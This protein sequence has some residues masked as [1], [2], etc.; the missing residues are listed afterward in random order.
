[1][2]TLF[3]LTSGEPPE[4]GLE[5]VF[6]APAQEPVPETPEA[7]AAEAPPPAT[8]MIAYLE[9][10]AQD[11]EALLPSLS[12][13]ELPGSDSPDFHAQ[14]QSVVDRVLGGGAS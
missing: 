8:A 5:K 11:L 1:M 7:A 6:S 2:K 4:Q 9:K 14:V 13:P 10:A 3:E 12:Q